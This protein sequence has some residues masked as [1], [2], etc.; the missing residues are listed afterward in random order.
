LDL[1]T[2]LD[3]WNAGKQQLGIA[4]VPNQS[5]VSQTD[6]W[7]V[8]IEGRKQT[9][10]KPVTSTITYRAPPA[11]V[12]FGTSVSPI[13][14]L[15]SPP[16]YTA[17]QPP[18]PGPAPSQPAPAPVVAPQPP[19]VATVAQRPVA[20]AGPVTKPAAFLAPIAL[21]A[22]IVFFARLSPRDATPPRSAP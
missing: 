4:L 19:P 21:L 2:F 1:G 20:F 5:E 6:A 8:T 12:G 11:D 16:S 3:A 18:L 9:G 22:G 7:H 17:P 10:A 13:I 15:P 14:T